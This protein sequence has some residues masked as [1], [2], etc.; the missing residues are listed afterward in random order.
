MSLKL[1]ITALLIHSRLLIF[2]FRNTKSTS[3][4]LRHGQTAVSDTTA[5]WKYWLW[6]AIW[7][8]L[9]GS[10]IP[11]SETP[12]MQIPTGLQCRTSS[13]EYGMM[14]RYFTPWGKHRKAFIWPIYSSSLQYLSEEIHCRVKALELM[15][16]HTQTNLKWKYYNYILH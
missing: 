2:S 11:S 6:T 13:S 10:Q 12:R 3:S 16:L 8:D 4:L 7:W 1:N 14:G 9:F 15:F 5:Q